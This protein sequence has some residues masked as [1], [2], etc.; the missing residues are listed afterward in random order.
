[1][2]EKTIEI[3]ESEYLHLRKQSA[4]LEALETGGVDN[5]SWYGES[6]SHLY[7]DYGEIKEEYL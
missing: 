3:S 6:I 2:A 5:W 1:M 7:D 4:I